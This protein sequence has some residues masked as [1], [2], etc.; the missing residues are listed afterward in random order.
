M[1]WIESHQNLR[2]HPK[3]FDLMGIMGWDIDTTLGKLFRFWWWCVDYAEDGDLRKH[4]SVRIGMSVGVNGG[5]EEFFV[6]AMK[7][8]GWIDVEPYFRV[9]DWWDYFGRFLQVKYK[10]FPHKW[11]EIRDLYISIPNNLPNNIPNGSSKTHNLTNLTNITNQ[12]KK[13]VFDFEK[14]WLLYP[15]KNRVGKKEAVRHFEASVKSAKDYEDIQISI[16]NYLLTDPVRK[17]FVKNAS[18]FF[19]NWRDFVSITPPDEVDK[20]RK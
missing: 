12:P 5:K 11:Q 1:A 7:K 19:N 15:P 18:T 9:H 3:V 6:E 4:N 20:W 17:G 2:E 10:N 13:E 16:K 8:S 14:I